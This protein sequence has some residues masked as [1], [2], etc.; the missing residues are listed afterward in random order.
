MRRE[1]AVADEDDFEPAIDEE[2]AAPAANA[3]T[4]RQAPGDSICAICENRRLEMGVACLRMSDF[5]VELSQFCDDQALSKTLS[6]LARHEP[7]HTF[8]PPS[9]QDTLLERVVATEFAMSRIDHV[10]QRNWSDM[11]GLSYCRHYSC[12]EEATALNTD[13]R[14]RARPNACQRV[15]WP[16]R[17][18]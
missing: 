7:R 11:R 6:I 16:L 4:A 13:V 1:L 15:P 17:A 18:Q 14:A 9:S 10:P 3:A 5:S 2:A 8:F 12:K